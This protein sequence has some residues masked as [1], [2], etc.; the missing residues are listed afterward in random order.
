MSVLF[1]ALTF[2]ENLL[3]T[4][5]QMEN[6]FFAL[7]ESMHRDCIVICDRGT[8]DASAC[9][10]TT[11]FETNVSFRHIPRCKMIAAN[12]DYFFLYSYIERR[13]GEAHEEQ[14]LEP[15]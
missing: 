12:G 2:Q 11:S 5:I 14:R 7:A 6:T 1:P 15:R 10:S 8:M 3:K 13:L 4:M 9:K